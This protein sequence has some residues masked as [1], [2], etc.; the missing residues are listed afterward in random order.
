MTLIV[1]KYSECHMYVLLEPQAQI[2]LSEF[3]CILMLTCQMSQLAQENKEKAC[4]S[5]QGFPLAQV[6]SLCSL[7]LLNLNTFHICR[8]VDAVSSFSLPQLPLHHLFL[9][10]KLIKSMERNGK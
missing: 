7:P 9:T 3:D 6:P 5:H 1:T 4:Q 8:W 10:E 2:S